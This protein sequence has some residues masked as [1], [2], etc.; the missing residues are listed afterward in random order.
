MYNILGLGR[1]NLSILKYLFASQRLIKTNITAIQL[2]FYSFILASIGFII[3]TTLLF[4]MLRAMYQKILC[5]ISSNS[6]LYVH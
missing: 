4:K 6:N 3:N 1:D 5:F 2:K